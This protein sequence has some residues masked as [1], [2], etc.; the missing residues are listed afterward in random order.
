MSHILDSSQDV[1]F[2]IYPSL[3]SKYTFL[4]WVILLGCDISADFLSDL[5]LLNVG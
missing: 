1:D 3:F 4:G 2:L 5:P